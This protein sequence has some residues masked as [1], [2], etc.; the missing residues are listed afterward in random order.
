MPADVRVETS[1][2]GQVVRPPA[3]AGL[4]ILYLPGDRYLS[5][6][7]GSAPG[8]ASGLAE[9]TGATV[10]CARYRDAFPAALDDVQAA[11]G[12]S[13]QA[14]LVLLAGERLGAG[15]AT[16]LLIRLRDAGTAL[17]RCAMLVSALLDLTMQ[18]SSLQ[19]NGVADPTFDVGRF[20]RRVAGYAAGT[21]RCHPLLSP[22]YANLDGLPPVQLLAAGNDPLLDDSLG[23]A[24]RAA[25]SG[26]S[27]DLRV[28]PDAAVLRAATL[29]AMAE[30]V[31]VLA[32][33]D[34]PPDPPIAATRRAAA[35][36]RG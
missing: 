35:S 10:V 12:Y 22:L 4:V 17:P 16:A 8:L 11:Y 31:A 27:V 23:F 9:R 5:S 18:A 13:Q 19:L 33:G 32:R 15:L 6:A 26:V 36:R 21:P 14:G 7:T 25:R 3:E 1:P 24:A 34:D 30:F 29:T 2:V 28:L 20:Q